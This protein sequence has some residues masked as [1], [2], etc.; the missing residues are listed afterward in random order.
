[1]AVKA[2]TEIV[3]VGSPEVR[4]FKWTGLQNGDT[5]APLYLPKHSDKSVQVSG[6]FGTGGSCTIEGSNMDSSFVWAT[7]NDPQGNALDVVSSKIEAVLENVYVIRPNVK[8]G[9]G[10]TLLD[11]YILMKVS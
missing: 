8:A 5:G 9:D 6:T 2:F 3:V 11:V 1:M 10:T 7:L 4:L